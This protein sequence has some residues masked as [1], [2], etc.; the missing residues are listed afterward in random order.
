MDLKIKD[1]IAIVTGG[2]NGIGEAVVLRLASEG[3][4]VI[5]ADLNSEAA[6]KVARAIQA[7]GGDALR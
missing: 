4:K 5:V 7:G 1:K 2:G 3:V 6:Q